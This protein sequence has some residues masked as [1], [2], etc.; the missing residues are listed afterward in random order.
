M[1]DLPLWVT[2]PGTLLFVISGFITFTGTLGLLR[3]RRFYSRLHAVT[4]G[5]TMGVGCI[6]TIM[7]LIASADAQRPMIHAI[8]II[9]LLF[10]VSPVTA[11]LLMRAGLRRDPRRPV[12]DD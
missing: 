1:N 7:I 12:S 4:L 5:N 3:L 8:L 9:L 2:I 6:V 11:I 10:L